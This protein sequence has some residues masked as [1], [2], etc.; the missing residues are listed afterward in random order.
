[1]AAEFERLSKLEYWKWKKDSENWSTM[2]AELRTTILMTQRQVITRSA[3]AKELMTSGHKDSLV[4]MM[5]VLEDLCDLEATAITTYVTALKVSSDPETLALIEVET[6]ASKEFAATTEAAIK[7]ATR[8][9][10]IR[11]RQ[12]R[13]EGSP[14]ASCLSQS[15]LSRHS[16][17]PTPQRSPQQDHNRI[18]PQA[19]AVDR[20]HLP[21]RLG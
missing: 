15:A 5:T 16:G 20:Q 2:L 11:L 9:R 18:R 19:R 21:A 6:T 10:Q 3:R 1:M 13:R 4:T 7:A 14:R 8:I 12:A 17:R